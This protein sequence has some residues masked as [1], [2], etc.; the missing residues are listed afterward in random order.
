MSFPSPSRVWPSITTC[1]CSRQVGP[2]STCPPTMQYGPISQPAPICALGWIT[3]V[4]CTISLSCLE[5]PATCAQ[6]AIR[7]LAL[8]CYHHKGHGRLADDFPLHLAH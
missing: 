2:S 8:R 1:E 4:E 6:P 7:R 5:L 3:A